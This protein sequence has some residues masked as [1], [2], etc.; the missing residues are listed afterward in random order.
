MI[1]TF[2]IKTWMLILDPQGTVNIPV[3]EAWTHG[4]DPWSGKETTGPT[5]FCPGEMPTWL[6]ESVHSQLLKAKNSNVPFL[7]LNVVVK[8]LN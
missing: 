1:S 5:Y 6:L 8:Q 3:K 7:F 2:F 4:M